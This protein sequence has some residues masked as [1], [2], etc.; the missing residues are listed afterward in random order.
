MHPF[1]TKLHHDHVD[2]RGLL[3]LLR[4]KSLLTAEPS[5]PAMGLLVDALYYLTRFPDVLHHPLEDRIAERLHTKRALAPAL[6]RE[7]EEQHQRISALGLDLLRDL[8]GA[9]REEWMSREL[10]ATNIQLYVERLRHNMVFEELVLLP[11]AEQMLEPGDWE[12]I[13]PGAMSLAPDPLFHDSVQDRFAQ[14]RAAIDEEI[15]HTRPV[16]P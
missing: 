5:D 2:L 7:L 8:E 9:L 15:A 4:R 13:A 14:L 3:T 11:A 10:V 16:A 12:E 6:L 1:L